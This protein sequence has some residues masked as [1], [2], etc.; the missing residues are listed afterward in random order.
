[1]S[2]MATEQHAHQPATAT[3][4]ATLEREHQIERWILVYLMGGVLILATTLTRTLGWASHDVAMIPAAIGA[5][6][7]GTPLFIEAVRELWTGKPTNATLAALAIIA[8]MATGNYET[9]GFL[10]FILLIA[11]Q[12]VRRTAWGAQRA[13]EQLVRLTPKKARLIEDGAEREVGIESV[14]VD[15][16][17][18]VRPGENLPVDGV[19]VSGE[20]TLNQASLTG[21]SV[22]VE[23]QVDSP[24][25]A[26][27]SNL[28]G[29]L[30]VRV[31]GVG[32][33][34]TIGKVTQLIG[35]AESSRT[36]RQLL[37]EQVA[38]YFVPVAITVAGLVWY[39]HSQSADE[40]VAA[41]AT[42]TAITVLVVLCPSAL[43]LSSPTAM[44][45][46][47]AAAARLG[48]MIKQTQY[49]EAA[50]HIDT[51]ILDKT[52]TLTT[53]V[54]AVSRL[55][56]A[57]GVEG[58]D[59]LQGAA[60]AEQQSNHPLARSIM[61]TAEDARLQPAAVESFEESHGR[62]VRAK[63]THGEVLAGRAA[64]LQEINPNIA[65]QVTLVEEKL[66]GMTGVHVMR[67]GKYLGA[68]GLADSLRPNAKG[69]VQRLRDLGVQRV[70]ILTGDRLEVAK[71]IGKT[72][73]VDVV[74][75]ECL[76]EEKHE[77][78]REMVDQGRRVLMVGDGINDGPSLAVADV[79]V[80]MGLSGSDIATNSAG[81]ALV[82]DDLSRIP[83]LIELARK[84]RVAVGQ[85][86]VASTVIAG[87]GL[88]LAATGSLGLVF[89]AFYHVVGDVF[90]IGNSFRLIRFGEAFTIA[91]DVKPK[92]EERTVR[93]A[94]AVVA[95]EH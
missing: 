58:A 1:M 81:V 85:N 29:T 47:F 30:D 88:S 78:V 77:I 33:E 76:P 25:Y 44:V 69:V 21:E 41:K 3:P 2:S 91:H 31:T 64:W 14:E 19:V 23:V 89:A 12:V 27:T 35:E 48:I 50:S 68:V 90:V 93:R 5:L 16:L 28:T 43:L 57:E 60:D 7:L 38:A 46:A 17:V 56:P 59:L 95:T 74:E 63:T 18:R 71:R 6:L 53:G 4:P 15:M 45:A 39:F 24:V 55:S 13:I 65:S 67:D 26:G 75:A 82:N 11:D 80:A 10:A 72:V 87:I 42:I 32:A 20:S 36:P 83:F 49:L 37:I 8:A 54:F 70:V 79:G 34:S 73:G 62:G 22:P 92:T 66:E 86:L 51:V 84:T 52:G 40:V 94:R 9:A 61:R